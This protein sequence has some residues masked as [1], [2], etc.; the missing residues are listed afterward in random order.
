[1]TT[2]VKIIVPEANHK[3][4]RCRII[5][6]ASKDPAV[7]LTEGHLWEDSILEHGTEVI[8]YVHGGARIILD[9]VD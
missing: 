3:R 7:P 5:T 9:E 1:M 2:E 6:P 4:V 8:K